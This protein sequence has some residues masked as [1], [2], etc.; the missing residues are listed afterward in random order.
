M[1]YERTNPYEFSNGVSRGR[2]IPWSVHSGPAL[3]QKWIAPASRF[4]KL[5]PMLYALRSRISSLP[6]A[7]LNLFLQANRSVSIPTISAQY[8][9]G[10]RH[11]SASIL[12]CSKRG[13][14]EVKM[15]K[16]CPHGEVGIQS[17]EERKAL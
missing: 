8:H 10:K 17:A 16:Y 2:N 14:P 7:S 9:S 1:L 5:Q 3:F 15:N 6:S 4:S 12:T 13:N 11:P